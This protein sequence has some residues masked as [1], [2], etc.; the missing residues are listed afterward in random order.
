[1]H[2][3]LLALSPSWWSCGSQVTTIVSTSCLSAGE[4]L[5]IIDQRDCIKSDFV[6]CN[7]DTVSNL[8]LAPVLEAHRARRAAD[9]NAIMTLVGWQGG[10]DGVDGPRAPRPLCVAAGRAAGRAPSGQHWFFLC[11]CALAGV[12]TWAPL[13]ASWLR[14]AATGAHTQVPTVG[15]SD[16]PLTF[17]P[18]YCL[19][20]CGRGP[21]HAACAS[22]QPAAAP[23]GQRAHCDAGP[24]FQ[25]RP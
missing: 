12:C 10:V 3:D 23:G 19:S 4:A 1:M 7:A 16:C 8:S 24:H 20:C 14:S 21:G 11:E 25:G 5:R 22:P 18:P 15:V 6:L 13:R 17:N 2:L 9:K